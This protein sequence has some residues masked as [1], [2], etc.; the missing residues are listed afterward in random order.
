M[1][2]TRKKIIRYLT[3]LHRKAKFNPVTL[4]FYRLKRHRIQ[5]LVKRESLFLL[6]L[7]TKRLLRNKRLR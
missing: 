2:V 3:K 7:R 4:L 1:K 5:S 6:R